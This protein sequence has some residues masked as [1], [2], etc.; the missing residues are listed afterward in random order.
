MASSRRDSSGCK[1]SWRVGCVLVQLEGESFSEAIVSERGQFGHPV[2]GEGA[3]D[4]ARGKPTSVES[5][6]V[7]QVGEVAFCDVNRDVFRVAF[8]RVRLQGRVWWCWLPGLPKAIEKGCEACF[9]TLVSECAWVSVCEVGNL[10]EC[11]EVLF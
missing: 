4:G 9:E 7:M 5:G 11:V 6:I 2:S 8:R 1:G 10:G 3:H